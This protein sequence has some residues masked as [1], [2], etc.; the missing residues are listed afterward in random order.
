M[1][2]KPHLRTSA[3]D[4]CPLG[5]RL[6]APHRDSGIRSLGATALVPAVGKERRFEKAGILPPGWA[7]AA[8]GDYRRQADTHGHQQAGGT[9]ISL[10]C[11]CKGTISP[12]TRPPQSIAAWRVAERTR[13]PGASERR[14]GRHRQQAGA[15][16]VGGTD[17]RRIASDA[18][19]SR[20]AISD[21][22][23]P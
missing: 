14:G 6:S 4:P 3:A 2:R 16:R 11:S 18:A 15:H 21:N 22:R 13:C 10:G 19:A 17:P 7:R 23:S 1:P 5:H 9:A 12:S 20:G 8:A